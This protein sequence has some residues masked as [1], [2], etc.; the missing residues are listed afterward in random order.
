MAEKRVLGVL[1]GQDM[2]L[3][4]LLQWA[5]GAEAIV[6]AD[7]GANR[8]VD[9]GIVPHVVVGDFDS[10]RPD[11]REKLRDMRE[12]PD[13]DKTDCDKLF[14]V[15]AEFLPENPITI[16]SSEGDLPDHFLASLHSAA[17]AN[18]PV[19]FAMRRGI[20]WVLR[21]GSTVQV[22]TK[23][24]R[25]ISLIP[26]TDCYGI[27]FEGVRWPLRIAKLNPQEQTSISNQATR[28][29]VSAKVRRGACLLF[30]EYPP[31]EMPFW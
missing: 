4:L 6:A 20:G 7:G 9:A 5:N 12:D 14:R 2:P 23:P 17:K 19:R 24:G 1:A 22:H 3:D 16:V 27:D 10:V 29:T 11:V 13:Q 25:R 18:M 31:E 30:A 15:V 8:L 28:P 21:D 26:L